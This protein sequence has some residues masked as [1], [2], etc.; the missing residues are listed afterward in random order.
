MLKKIYNKDKGF[1]IIEVLIVLA[2][3]GLIL[4]I[5]FLAVPSLQRNSRNTAMKNDV[6]NVVGG[7]GEYQGAN[8][9][10]MPTT[11]LAT[12]GTVDFTGA[13][14]TNPTSINVQ[15]STAV[16][17]VLTTPAGSVTPASGAIRV[18]I[19][20]RCDGSKSSRAVAAIYSIETSGDNAVRQCI[21]S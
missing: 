3:A 16:T 8:S 19:G 2:I 4:L 18:H 5:V 11:I 1:T 7:I 12:N 21:E 15:G 13:T 9:G 10:K 14:G 17:S 20:W 6:Q